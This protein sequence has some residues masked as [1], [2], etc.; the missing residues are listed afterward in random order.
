MTQYKRIAIH[1]SK[2]VFT[3]HGMDA[4]GQAGLRY[5]ATIGMRE[6]ATIW[7]RI[8]DRNDTIMFGPI[9]S[10]QRYV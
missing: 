1:T 8:S 6:R 9:V 2:S 7:M 5:C 10:G 3:P 4:A